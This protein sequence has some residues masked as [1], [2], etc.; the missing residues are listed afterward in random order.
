MR[1]ARAAPLGGRA[2]PFASMSRSMPTAN[3]EDPRRSERYPNDATNRSERYP[4]DA[5]NRSERYPNDASYRD[6][7]DATLQSGPLG[8]RRRHA[9]NKVLKTDPR[10]GRRDGLAAAG[11]AGGLAAAGLARTAS[12]LAGRTASAMPAMEP[13]I[14]RYN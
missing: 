3:A 7:S 13:A 1:A 9:P 8:A 6:L 4:N 12:T 2:R 14:C 10:S 11:L 5:T